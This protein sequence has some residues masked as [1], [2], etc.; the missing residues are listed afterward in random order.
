MAEAVSDSLRYLHPQDLDAIATYLA[1]IPPVRDGTDT[2]AAFDHGGPATSEADVRG[3][4]TGEGSLAG[5]AALYSGN[6]ASCHQPTGAGTKGQ[7]FP[8]LF[9]NTVTG[10]N[11]ADNLI[12]TILQG[13]DR[14]VGGVRAFMPRFDNGSSI[15]PLT[16][17]Q[18]SAIANYV[19][20]TFGNPK[21]RV[22]V[23]DVAT[24]RKSR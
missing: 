24:A 20:Q 13:I 2:R 12:S 4:D 23:K 21:V 14:D 15:Q 8:V 9:H 3:I 19:L 5:G 7:T 22:S 17:E 18:I 10:A 1:T 6:C 11:R 16:D